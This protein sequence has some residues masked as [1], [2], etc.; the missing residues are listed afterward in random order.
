MFSGLLLEKLGPQAS[1]DA[2]WEKLQ[3]YLNQLRC[4][5]VYDLDYVLFHHRSLANALL[6]PH[7]SQPLTK[8][9]R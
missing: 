9:R 5:E 3:H 2:L 4:G 7:Q 1:W 8:R 6:E